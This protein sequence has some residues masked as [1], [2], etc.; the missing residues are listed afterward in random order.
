MNR[1]HFLTLTASVALAPAA[2]RKPNIVLVMLDDLGYGDVGC[3][4]QKYIRTP[5]IDKLATEGI[6]FTSAYAGAA[7]CAPS[8]AVLMTGLHGGHAP[9][10][11]NAGTIPIKKEDQTLAE[12]LRSAG[13]ATGG[14]GKWGLG[15]AGTEGIPTRQGFDEFFGYL[16]QVHAHSYF[17]DFLWDNESKYKLPAGVYSADVIAQRSFEFV[18]KHKDKPFFLYACWTLPH[19]KFEIPDVEPYVNEDWPDGHKR[20]AAMITRA[21]RHIGHLMQLLK[22]LDLERNTVFIFTSDNGAHSGKEKGFE[23]FRSNGDLRGEKGELYE[24]GIRVPMIVRWP[25]HVQPASTTEVPTAFCDMV[26]TLADIAGAK[27]GDVDGL[28][29]L[30]TLSAKSQPPRPFLYWEHNVYDQ[31]AAQL[32]DDRLVQAVRHRDW[33]GVRP[34]PGAPLELYDLRTDPAETTNV[35]AA[36]PA[37]VARIE[38]YLRSA[39]SAP[40]PHN[41]GSMK[42]VS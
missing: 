26:P 24:G 14:F 9:V 31:K 23:F 11:A 25:G 22:Q 17:T 1:R 41:T 42:W 20:Y 8:R 15:D 4:G 18:R 19:G 10:R 36:N 27:H 13:Y 38:E 33:K 34:K 6:R 3:Y 7:V 21:D 35:A 32:R 30:P 12:I 5:H 29:M 2:A 37:V 28:S 39:R 16:H 40:R